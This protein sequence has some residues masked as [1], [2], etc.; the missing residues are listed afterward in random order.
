MKKEIL[1]VTTRLEHW[2]FQDTCQITVNTDAGLTVHTD[3]GFADKKIL[4]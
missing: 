1:R 2:L 3:S 4:L